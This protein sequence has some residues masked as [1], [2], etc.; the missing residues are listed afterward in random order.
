[1]E[2]QIKEKKKSLEMGSSVKLTATGRRYRR[3]YNRCIVLYSP[4]KK[5]RENSNDGGLFFP[6]DASLDVD[7]VQNEKGHLFPVWHFVRT[8]PS[9]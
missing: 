2:N 6:L 7:I 4:D 3:K 8:K 5:K 9:V 1:M